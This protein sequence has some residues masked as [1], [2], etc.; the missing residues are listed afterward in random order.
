MPNEET[1]AHL[2]EFYPKPEDETCVCY[3]GSDVSG[4]DL[5]GA[6]T[7]EYSKTCQWANG[8]RK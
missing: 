7:V 4:A 3:A 8:M 1:K 6:C 5:V 2:C